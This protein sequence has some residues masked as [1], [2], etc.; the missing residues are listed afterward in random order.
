[1]AAA[2]SSRN[3][4]TIRPADPQFDPWR[5]AGTN[6]AR[7]MVAEA[8]RMVENYETYFQLRRRKRRPVD[9][10]TFEITVEALLCDAIHRHLTAPQSALRISLSN[11]VL[12]T[13]NRYRPLV[14]SKALPDIVKRLGSPELAFLT[15]TMGHQG[16]AGE[17]G[18]QTT[19][20][21]GTKLIARIHEHDL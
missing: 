7:G 9:Q 19:I 8:Q 3:A 13:A 15:V 2:R 11:R 4:G 18:K 10:N 1:M 20:A 17:E 6:S 5:R 16:F 14:M 21:A 12:G